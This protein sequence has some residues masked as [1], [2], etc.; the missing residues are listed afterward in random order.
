L[1]CHDPGMLRL[2]DGHDQGRLRLLRLH[3][4]HAGLLQLLI[5]G[6]SFAGNPGAGVISR[7]RV[8]PRVSRR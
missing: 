2:H 7:A 4:Q 1:L 3:E 8:R 5:A 6:R